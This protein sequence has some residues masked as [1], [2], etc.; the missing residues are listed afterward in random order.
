M[1]AHGARRLAKMN[2]NLAVILGVEA[3]CAAQGIEVRAP[4][5]TSAPLQSAMEA[6]RRRVPPLKKDR[7]LA[8]DI[9]TAAE[10]IHSDALAQAAGLE[11][12]L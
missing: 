5:A 9:E 1:A 7:I 10:L 2:D 12:A 8:G 3:L 4:L 6:L 11:L